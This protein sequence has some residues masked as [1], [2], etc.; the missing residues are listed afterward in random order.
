[1][2]RQCTQPKRPRNVTWYKDKAMLAEAQEA[3]QILDEEQLAF[4]A[5]PG[6]QMV[7]LFRQ[8]FQTMLLFRLR[9]LILMILTVMIS[10]MQ[11][12]FLGPTFP[13]MVLTLSQRLSEDFRKLFTPQQEL[14][15][16]QAF[17]FRISNPTIKSSNKPPVKLEV[18]SELPKVSFMTASLKKLKFHLA[19]FDSVVKKRTTPDART[20]VKQAK[21]KQLLDKELDFAC[22]H[23]QRIQDLLV[24]VR[25]TCPN[26]IKLNE[27]KVVVTPKNKVKKVRITSANIVPPKKTTSHS[28]E[29]QKPEL[30]LCSRKPKIVKNVGS[31]KKA[32]IVEYENANHSEPNHTWGSN[33][34]DIPSSSSTCHNSKFLA[35][36]RFG[37]DHIARIMGYGDYQMGNVTISRVYYVE[38]LGHNLFSVGQFC[39]TNLEV[40]FWKNTCFIRN[41]E[42]VDLIFGPEIQICTQFLLMTCLKHLRS[43]FYPKHQRLRAGYETIACALGKSK[44]TSHQPKAEDTNQEILYLLHMD[45]C[46]PMRVASINRKRHFV[47]FI[48]M[49]A[50]RI[51]HLLPA[52]LSKTALSK[53][54]NTDCYTQN[55]SL[56]CLRYNKTLYK[57]M[58]DKK[59]D[60]SFFHVFGALCYPTNDNDDLG[61]L[62]A[63]A[64]IGIFIGYVPAKKAFRIYNKRTQKIIETIHVT[65]DELT[66]MASEQFSSRLVLHSMT[67]ATSSSGLVPNTVSQ[68]PCIPPKKDDWNHLFNLCFEESPKTKTFHDDPL[69]EDSTSQGSSS[70]MRQTHT[71]FEHLELKNFKQAMTEPSWIDSMQ[72]EI[73]EFKRLQVWELAPCPDK[74]LLIN[75]KQEEVIDSEESFEPVAR[76]E[77]IHIFIANVAHKNM[78]I[79][80]M[81]VKTAFLNGELKEEKYGLLSTDYVDTPM[82]EKNKLDE[83]LQGTP[84]DATLYSGMIGSL[85]YLTSSRPDLSMQSAYVLG[86]RQSL[87]KTYAD[88]DLAGCQDTRRSTSE[89]AQFLDD[90][91]EKVENGVV[92]LYFIQTKYQLADIFTKPFPRERFNFLIENL[93]MRS[94]SPKTLKRLAEETK[95]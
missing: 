93:S 84:V 54:I 50:S 16:E 5:D 57:L 74:V 63:K 20:E 71:P 4:L 13:T 88:A 82:V 41:L 39:D 91:L 78:T 69:H 90:K 68:Q 55:R 40:A 6:V 7:K 33:A 52:L 38:G 35:T 22:K 34:T 47:N 9:I 75:L 87:P 81:D 70:N 21:A 30:K 17:W 95:E 8:S 25:D 19:Q 62:D 29:T 76:I 44:K 85:M 77:A 15:A 45:L 49:L 89:S 53:A 31:S 83:D 32:K 72:E 58:Q 2:A 43:V 51:K 59:P 3:R 28:V 60:L 1:M 46:G 37:K 36:V 86:I 67:P 65:F 10:R 94:M 66:A 12:R 42:G 18:P 61:K 48:K 73:H 14:D 80:Q 26:A 92:E 79:F 64:D 27:K 56:T 11:K 23:A 24:Y